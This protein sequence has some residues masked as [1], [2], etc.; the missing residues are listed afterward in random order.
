LG[1]DQATLPDQMDKEKWPQLRKL[2]KDTFAKKTQAE[3]IKIFNNLDACVTPVIEY[4]KILS[5]PQNQQRKVLIPF[6]DG[7]TTAPAPKLSRTPAQV[8]F[9]KQNTESLFLSMNLS[10]EEINFIS[11]P[12]LRAAL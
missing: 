7:Y 9:H 4:T 1:V 10:P 6:N 3:W 2:F 8:Q 12:Q 5:H 11:K